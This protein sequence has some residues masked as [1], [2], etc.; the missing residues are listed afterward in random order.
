MFCMLLRK[1]L[2][3][4]VIEGVEQPNRDRLLVFSIGGYDEMGDP[5][6]KKLIVEMMGQASNL[7]LVGEDGRIIDCM[8][9]ISSVDGIH[10]NLLPGMFYELPPAQKKPDF[11]SVPAADKG[12]WLADSL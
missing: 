10:R 8:R 12:L 3:G 1:H 2:C 4:T 9:R 6:H 5:V 7:L 11:F